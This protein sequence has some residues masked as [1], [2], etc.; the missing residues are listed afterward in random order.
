[1][2]D[3]IDKI[4]LEFKDIILEN[5][6]GLL[7]E[8]YKRYRDQFPSKLYRYMPIERHTISNLCMLLN[9][10][11]SLSDFKNFNDPLD[12]DILK[13]IQNALNND[14]KYVS[15]RYD[16]NRSVLKSLLT[17]CLSVKNP[18]E[19]NSMLMW[20]YYAD[21]HKGICVEYDTKDFIDFVIETH[22]EFNRLGY[23]MPL[24][25]FL[26]VKYI[27]EISMSQYKKNMMNG[28]WPITLFEKR[29]CWSH[30]DEWRIFY[31]HSDLLVDKYEDRSIKIVPQKIYLGC[32]I[33]KDTESKIKECFSQEEVEIENVAIGNFM[34]WP[35]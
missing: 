34:D 1:M 30:E 23:E 7:V 11:F 25:W 3:L 9:G 29:D 5:K 33:N 10:K 32:N 26:P 12:S 17:K 28:S 18:V 13:I 15:D 24:C 20:A 8:L 22:Q 31:G 19:I 16:G 35:A 6:S 4:H 2:S 14:Q 27:S 21:S